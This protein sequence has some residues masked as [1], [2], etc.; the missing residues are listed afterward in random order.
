MPSWVTEAGDPVQGAGGILTRESRAH[1]A[2]FLSRAYPQAL[3]MGV[4]RHFWF[5]FPFYREGNTGWGLFEPN[6]EAPY[7]GLAA[8]AT[9]T[10]ALGRGDFLGKIAVPGDE[11]RP[12]FRA[13][14]GTAAV[15]V[16]R[17]AD[18]G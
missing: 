16:W 8:M 5:V 1:Q 6:Q 18:T 11:A 15:A 9:A 13:R 2:A 14:D 10:Y 4:E 3:A 7:P 17:G 12:R